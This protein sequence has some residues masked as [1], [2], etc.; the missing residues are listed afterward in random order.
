MVRYFV[1]AIFGTFLISPVGAVLPALGE[2]PLKISKKKASTIAKKEDVREKK[3]NNQNSLMNNP[4]QTSSQQASGTDKGMQNKD[5]QDIKGKAKKTVP[6]DARR[7][8]DHKFT[9]AVRYIKE[10]PDTRFKLQNMT[11]DP[12]F[13]LP[14]LTSLKEAQVLDKI[15]DIGFVML[16]SANGK[17]L[18]ES[19]FLTKILPFLGHLDGLECNY[20]T[21]P[22]IEV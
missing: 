1:F 22:K 21:R 11:I 13:A 17:V 19:A 6:I 3:P 4:Q 8:K 18:E 15:K 5:L 12:A 9:E 7:L 20:S 10:H 16:S 2:T 14:L